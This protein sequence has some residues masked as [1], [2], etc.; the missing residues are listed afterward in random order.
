MKNA[1][2]PSIRVAPELRAAA[3]DVLQTGESL[4]SF[5]E[6]SLRL[7]IARRQAQQEFISRGLASRAEAARTGDYHD[8]DDVLAELDLLI[9]SAEEKQA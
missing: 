5:A 3:E 2:I 9:D 1:T 8:A 7:N 6:Q 4:S